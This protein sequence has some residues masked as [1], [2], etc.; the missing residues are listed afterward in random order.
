[1]LWHIAWSGA[2]I[3]TRD[4][5]MPDDRSDFLPVLMAGLAARLLL[6]IGLPAAPLSSANDRVKTTGWLQPPLKP[7]G[8]F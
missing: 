8:F 4:G 6:R 5:Q 7:S 3:E 1:M 2:G